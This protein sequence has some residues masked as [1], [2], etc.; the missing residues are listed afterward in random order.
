[1]IPRASRC[2]S[3][4]RYDFEPP[5]PSVNRVFWF[6]NFDLNPAAT[7]SCDCHSILT[8]RKVEAKFDKG[9][10]HIHLPK[11]AEVAPC[12]VCDLSPPMRAVRASM[13]VHGLARSQCSGRQHHRRPRR[14][15]RVCPAQNPLLADR[16]R[17]EKRSIRQCAAIVITCNL[18]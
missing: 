1:M 8:P 7:R 2:S 5:F 9:V 15:S 17:I 18:P 16:L 4:A 14:I 10:L 12:W 13:D 6:P 11:P 3:S